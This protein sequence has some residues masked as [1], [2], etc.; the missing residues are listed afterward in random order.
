MDSALLWLLLALA[1][2]AAVVAIVGLMRSRAKSIQ[3]ELPGI[4]GKVEA[5]E[6]PPVRPVIADLAGPPPPPAFGTDAQLVR[7]GAQLYKNADPEDH[8]VFEVDS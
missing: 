8:V 7:L 6:G 4:R 2:L 1:F 3:I 5:F